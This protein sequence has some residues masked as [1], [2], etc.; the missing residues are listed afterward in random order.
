MPVDIAFRQPQMPRARRRVAPSQFGAVIMTMGVKQAR[1]DG[2]F[3]GMRHQALADGVRACIGLGHKMQNKPPQGSPRLGGKIEGTGKGQGTSHLRANLGGQVILQ[4]HAVD[5]HQHLFGAFFPDHR[6]WQ[7]RVQNGCGIWGGCRTCRSLMP[8][9]RRLLDAR[10]NYRLYKN[11]LPPT[12]AGLAFN[13]YNSSFFSPLSAEMGALW[14]AG[15]L[16]DD[17]KLPAVAEQ[18][19]IT[20]E[21]LAW[22]E[23]RTEGKHARGTNIIPF[24][25]HQIDELLA[26]LRLPIGGMRRFMEWQMPVKP[27]AYAGMA[28]KLLARQKNRAG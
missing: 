19:R 14:I 17:L 5:L 13:G 23:E 15:Y 10:G 12:Q 4:C 2:R 27:G 28:G 24:S 1:H 22:M 25:M 11:I 8:M 16:M 20:D 6:C 3:K 7:M 9:C 21:R 18:L 26:D